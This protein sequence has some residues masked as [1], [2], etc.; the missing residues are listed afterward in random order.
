MLRRFHDWLRFWWLKVPEPRAFSAIY[1]T[2]Y[3][4]A[5][6]TGLVTLL[7]PPQ[8]IRAEIGTAAMASIGVLLLIGAAIGMVGGAW[9]HWKLERVGLW[10]MSGALLIYAMLVTALHFTSQG[11]RLTQLGVILLA[12]GT[13]TVRYLMIRRYTFRPRG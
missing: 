6:L 8:T 11:S 2:L 3:G 9:E 5:A 10:F 12:L 7:N 13:F 4:I 1:T